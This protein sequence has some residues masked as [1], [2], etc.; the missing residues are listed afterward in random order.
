MLP[1]DEYIFQ[2]L[3]LDLNDPDKKMVSVSLKDLFNPDTPENS[4]KEILGAIKRV[5]HRKGFKTIVQRESEDKS[6]LEFYK[7]DYIH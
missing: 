4:I 2:Q 3:S 6:I 7:Y 5:A 1:F